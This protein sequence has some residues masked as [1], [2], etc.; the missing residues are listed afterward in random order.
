M[1]RPRRSGGPRLLT[2]TFKSHLIKSQVQSKMLGLPEVFLG[3]G[4]ARR[5]TKRY[6]EPRPAGQRPLRLNGLIH[7]HSFI[8]MTESFPY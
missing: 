8:F 5:L 6:V 7:A 3:E 1:T 4:E 2:N